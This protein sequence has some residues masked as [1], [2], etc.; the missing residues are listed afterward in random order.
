M[1][2][3]RFYE[4]YVPMNTKTTLTVLTGSNTHLQSFQSQGLADRLWFY[5][6]LSI[7]VSIVAVYLYERSRKPKLANI[8]AN[9]LRLS[10]GQVSY[11]V[12][13]L[14][15][16]DHILAATFLDWQRRG[17]VDQINLEEKSLLLFPDSGPLL[18]NEAYLMEA[19]LRFCPGG[20]LSFQ[21]IQNARLGHEEDFYQALSLWFSK[22]DSSL[23]QAGLTYK[24]TRNHG[25]ALVYFLLAL[26]FYFLGFISIY[27]ESNW[28]LLIVFGACLYLW[29]S[30]AIY[31]GHP[32][33]GQ[34][35][36]QALSPLKNG[37][38]SS[39]R[40]RIPF[41]DEYHIYLYTLSMG[42]YLE[43]F[44]HYKE[45]DQGLLKLIRE[46]FIGQISYEI[47]NQIE[48]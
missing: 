5:L 4:R 6:G 37:N 15:K 41:L 38:L 44:S 45:R 13:G 33:K 3:V 29:L 16:A 27:Q 31:N 17:F 8:P 10:P 23:R 21:T 11:L 18:E 48:D 24:N 20:V 39:I 42:R 36:Y 22:I 40:E 28:G 34:G 14:I 32:P 35:V 12:L 19:L 43:E 30:I 26:A 2:Q 9:D 47:P 25:N 46:S 1:I 7:L